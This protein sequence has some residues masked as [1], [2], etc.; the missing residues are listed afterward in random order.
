MSRIYT[1][2]FENVAVA[3]A[4]DFFE[5]TP[6]DDIP[7]LIHA[8]FLDQISDV[9]DAEEEMLR[10]RLIRGHTTSGS[11]G[12]AP[13]PRPLDARDAAASFA[14]EVNNTTIASAGTPINILSAAFN[15]RTGYV[16]MPTPEIRPRVDQGDTTIVLR[17]MA[18]PAD[19]VQMSGTIY[20]EEL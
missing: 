2:E 1:V 8:I 9:G 16:Y 3:A 17:L 19:S 10:L 14:A 6:A 13:T 15:I 5:I 18:N 20:I 7:C 12:T 11:G 4:Q